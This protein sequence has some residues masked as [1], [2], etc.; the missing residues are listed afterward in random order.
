LEAVLIDVMTKACLQGSI[1]SVS[2]R[3]TCHI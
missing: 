2:R 3:I 1:T